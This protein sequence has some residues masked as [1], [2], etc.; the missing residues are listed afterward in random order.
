MDTMQ[1]KNAISINRLENP[2][3]GDTTGNYIGGDVETQ[4]NHL[5]AQIE[6]LKKVPRQKK[7][8]RLNGRPKEPEKKERC[9][10]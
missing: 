9:N 1:A 7:T 5:K 10:K 3:K 2:E 8:G 4:T 6:E